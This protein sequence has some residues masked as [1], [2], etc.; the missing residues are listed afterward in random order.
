VKDSF[1]VVPVGVE[2]E[3]RVVPGVIVRPQPRPS[4]VNPT[5]LEGCG[6]ERINRSAVWRGERN[7][8][9]TGRHFLFHDPEVLIVKREARPLRTLDDPDTERPQ[10]PLVER[11][12]PCEIAYRQLHMIK[13]ARSPIRHGF[14]YPA[15]RESSLSCASVLSPGR[16]SG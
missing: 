12:T 14:K 11:A 2:D 13:Q 9:R 4:V 16:V 6:V 5:R 15:L 3:C 8:H 10:C 1:Y 7:V